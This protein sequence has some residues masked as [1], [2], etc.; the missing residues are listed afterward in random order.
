M[1][2]CRQLWLLLLWL[3]F[4]FLS[5]HGMPWKWGPASNSGPHGGPA[6]NG[7]EDSTDNIVIYSKNTGKWRY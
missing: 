5:V 6:W 7:G 3:C 1:Y 4:A 2:L